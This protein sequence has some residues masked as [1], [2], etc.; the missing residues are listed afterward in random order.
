M[1][2]LRLISDFCTDE[3]RAAIFDHYLEMFDA[4]LSVNDTAEL[5][6]LLALAACWNNTPSMRPILNEAANKAVSIGNLSIPKKRV[7]QIAA[8]ICTRIDTLTGKYKVIES[9]TA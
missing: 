2:T 3:E 5:G 1:A 9:L 8:E 4:A 6:D 7:N